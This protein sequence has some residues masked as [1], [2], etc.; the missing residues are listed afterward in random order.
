MPGYISNLLNKIC[1][2]RLKSKFNDE[3]A[4]T[5]LIESGDASEGLDV[6]QPSEDEVSDIE[7]KDIEQEST[8]AAEDEV[9][10]EESQ[11]KKVD[12]ILKTRYQ[13]LKTLPVI[14]TGSDM[15]RISLVTDTINSN[16]FFGGVAT[17]II[18]AILVSEKAGRCLRIITRMEG[19]GEENFWDLIVREKLEFTQEVE[20]VFLDINDSESMVDAYESE[21]FITTS[22]WTTCSAKKA[23]SPENIIYILQEDERM[24]YAYGDEHLR[25]SETLHSDDIRYLVNTKLLYDH[26]ISDGFEN[27]VSNG[28]WF[29]PSFS[30][31]YHAG[32]FFRKKEKLRFFFYA[33]P[34]HPR[35]LYYR[36]IEVI[37]CAISRGIINTD[38]WDVI[39]IGNNTE[40][41]EFSTGYKPTILDSMSWG[42]YIEFLRT[43]DLGLSLMYTPHP[44]YP[45]LD[46][47]ASGAVVVTN[48][49]RNKQ[50]LECYSNNI[51]CS[52]LD[53]ESLLCALS[54]GVS[55]AK[56]SVVRKSNYESNNISKDWGASFHNVIQKYQQ[57]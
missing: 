43:I 36:G 30:E 15:R 3:S 51:I 4:D 38:E 35:N 13:I 21:L 26:L 54:D 14:M 49:Y 45:P 40:D 8:H 41:I 23:I 57:E 27:M 37:N 18:L 44:S 16:H 1:T 55:L 6:I 42:D 29:N 47:A 50:S 25:C 32:D 52:D 46:L 11:Y 5:E 39:Y 20:F 33:R 56:N 2:H 53:V 9:F 34:S 19:G 31:G 7:Q 24:F 10:V 12:D 17:A 22:W 28:E 48:K